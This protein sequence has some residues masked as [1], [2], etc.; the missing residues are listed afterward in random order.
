MQSVTKRHV[1]EFKIQQP[2]HYVLRC[3]FSVP[4][5]RMRESV[6]GDGPDTVSIVS[7]YRENFRSYGVCACVSLRARRCSFI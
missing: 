2:Q 3:R 6:E 7:G 1:L 4:L 5:A